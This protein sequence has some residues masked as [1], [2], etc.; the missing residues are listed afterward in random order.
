MHF[1]QNNAGCT[2]VAV[3]L[4]LHLCQTQNFNLTPDYSHKIFSD[5]RVN[6]VLLM[7]A[8]AELSRC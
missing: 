2:C 7:E 4:I 6:Y 3:I 5:R 1:W 8:L